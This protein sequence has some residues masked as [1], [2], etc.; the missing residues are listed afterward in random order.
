MQINT[1]LTKNETT[2]VSRT[3]NI[4][5]QSIMTPS[6]MGRTKISSFIL[7]IQSTITKKVVGTPDTIYYNYPHAYH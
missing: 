3:Q 6:K 5:C 2:P 4:K 7:Q 1:I